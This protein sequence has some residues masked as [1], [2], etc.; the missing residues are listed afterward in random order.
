MTSAELADWCQ[1]QSEDAARQVELFGVGGVR[2]LLK[3]PDDTTQDI[4]AGVVAHQTDNIAMFARLIAA[5][6]A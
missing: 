2:A 4:T 5:L 3:M 6:T 1:R